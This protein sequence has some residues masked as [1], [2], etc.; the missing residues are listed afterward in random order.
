MAIKTV[1]M[2]TCDWCDDGRIEVATRE[3]AAKEATLAGW[4]LSQAEGRRLKF[5]CPTCV[6]AERAERKAE[7]NASD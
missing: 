4:D 5:I 7:L 6:A 1:T 2:V 3:S